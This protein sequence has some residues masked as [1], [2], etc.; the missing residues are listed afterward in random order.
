MELNWQIISNKLTE[1][2]MLKHTAV[3]VKILKDNPFIEDKDIIKPETPTR[4]CQM[5]LDA[6]EGKKILTS[7]QDLNCQSPVICLGFEEP[8]Y[9]DIEPRIRPA[10]TKAVYIAALDLFTTDPDVILF[11]FTPRQSMEFARAI[12]LLKNED[13]TVEFGARMAVCGEAVAKPYIE[14]KPNLTMLCYGARIHTN[15]CDDELVFGI[16]TSWIKE[17]VKSQVLNKIVEARELEKE[18]FPS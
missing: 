8:R 10:T 11:I 18:L 13:I 16:P 15:F 5:V 17:I 2:F 9:A 7:A 1:T 6:A 4:F 3:G 12:Q 14:K